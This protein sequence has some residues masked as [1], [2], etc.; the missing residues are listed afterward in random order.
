[1]SGIIWLTPKLTKRAHGKH[2][3]VRAALLSFSTTL[4]AMVFSTP[5]ACYYFGTLS[6]VSLLSNLLCLWLVS[7]V[8]ALGL[9]SVL[10]AAAVPQLGALCALLPALGIRAVLAIAGL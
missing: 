8:F 5:L 1:M 7:V 4:G 10:I 9:L 3:L 6:I 2:K